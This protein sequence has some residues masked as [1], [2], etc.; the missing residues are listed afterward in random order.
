MQLPRPI[1]LLAKAKSYIVTIISILFFLQQ[2]TKSQALTISLPPVIESNKITATEDEG[3][4]NAS[5]GVVIKKD[6][7]IIKTQEIIYNNKSQ[8]FTIDNKINFNFIDTANIIASDGIVSKNI[9]S[10]Y[11]NNANMIFD[12]GAFIKSDTIKLLSQNEILLKKSYFSI[13]PNPKIKNE[14]DNKNHKGLIAIDSTKTLINKESENITLYNSKVKILNIPVFYTPFLSFS[15]PMSSK[16]STGFLR[17][18]YNHHSNMGGG[19]NLQYYINLATNKDNTISTTYFP[20]SNIYIVKNKFRHL[21]NNGQYEITLEVAKNNEYIKNNTSEQ[22]IEKNNRFYLETKGKFNISN[23]ADISHDIKYSFDKDY[24]LDYKMIFDDYLESE[25][26]YNKKNDNSYKNLKAVLIQDLADKNNATLAL[27]MY[28]SYQAHKIKKFIKSKFSLKQDFLTTTKKNDILYNR[29]HITPKIN[30]PV[31]FYNNQFDLSL[32]TKN[33][34]YNTNKKYHDQYDEFITRSTTETAISWDMPF[35]KRTKNY[36]IFLTPIVNT[37]YS[38]SNKLNS[39][40]PILDANNRE[41]TKETIFSNNRFSGLDAIETGLR[42]NY[43]FKSEFLSQKYGNSGLSLGQSYR[44]NYDDSSEIKIKEFEDKSNIIGSLYYNY[45]NIF[46]TS[47]NFQLNDTYLNELNEILTS[48]NYKRLSLNSSYIWL[49]NEKTKEKTQEHLNLQ[50]QIAL[51]NKIKQAATIN[52]DFIENAI[53]S[54]TA[55][56]KYDGCCIATDL[57]I[58]RN[59]QNKLTKAETSY[60]F[61]VYIKKLY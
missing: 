57:S 61:N 21:V 18:S 31:I 17:P 15:Y 4:I 9:N 60:S 29:Y 40:I 30:I 6:D 38:K 32:K 49:I 51:T 13:C 23:Q 55:S 10:G 35:L 52:Y 53:I 16:R 3:I 2:T 34:F 11:M 58:T 45:N 20:N 14:T 44:D 19:F 7:L 24:L 26:S 48:I 50:Y 1:S 22:A 12:N 8:N 54:Q 43:G 37:A 42:I 28:E 5:G 33:T 36:D 39:E 27:P 41:I 47:Y 59:N 46:S 56:I 25:I